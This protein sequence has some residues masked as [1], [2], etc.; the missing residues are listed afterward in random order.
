MDKRKGDGCPPGTTT[1]SVDGK[2]LCGNGN[3]DDGSPGCSSTN[4]NVNGIPYGQICGKIHAYQYGST[5]A[6]GYY[7]KG[8]ERRN[9]STTID[10]A[11]VDGISL[12]YD[13]P[14]KHIWTFAGGLDEYGHIHTE[15]KC[16]CTDKAVTNGAISA[17]SFVGDDYFCETAVRN[18]HWDLEFHPEDPL[19]DGKGC[20]NFDYCCEQKK[21][22]TTSPWFRKQLSEITT[23]DIEMRMCRDDKLFI[24]EKNDPYHKDPSH[25]DN[26]G[27]PVEN[28]DSINFDEDTPFDQLAIYVR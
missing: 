22:T 23:A 28:T 16:A 26:N 17:P 5:D 15:F 4:M 11:Y 6:F 2:E 3:N 12:T 13:K 18:T 9:A 24:P 8:N 10:G 7:D 21:R 25:K 27:H 1:L 19:W 14:R 20:E